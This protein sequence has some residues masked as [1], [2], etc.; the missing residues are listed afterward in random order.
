MRRRSPATLA[1]WLLAIAVLACNREESRVAI[2]AAALLRHAMPELVDGYHAKAGVHVDV[3]YGASDALGDQVERG[4]A[5]DGLVFAEDAALG[6][7]VARGRVAR[8]SR[9]AIAS[10]T[11]VLAGP[12]GSGHTF[13]SLGTL[14]ANAK[15]AIGDPATV[16]AG[17]YARTYLQSIGVWPSVE[18]RLVYGGD[19]AGVLA[20]ALRGSAG[21]AIV[22][23]TDAERASPLVILD[24]P[25]DTPI[26]DIIAGVVDGAPRA[27]KARAFLE[28]LTSAEGQAILARHGFARPR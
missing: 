16:P 13:A 1:C 4:I 18:S 15:I 28:Y 11:I 5:L 17:R 27:A 7:L 3:T 20:H 21:V 8:D 6:E 9:R 2:G 25:S 22:Y 10:T 19:V 24:Q 23:R 26:V 12:A 14:S